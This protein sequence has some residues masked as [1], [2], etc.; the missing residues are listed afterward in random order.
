M[1]PAIDASKIYSTLGNN[2]SLVPLAVKDVANSLGLTT[3]S[4]IIG[5]ELEGKDRF[6]DEFGTQAIWLFGLP[7]F[8]K[9]TD[10]TLYKALK[11]DPK[12]DVRLLDNPDILDKAIELEKNDKIKKSLLNMKNNP[13]FSRSLAL[14]KFGIATAMT[15]ISYAALT[16]YRHK[17][18]KEA[19]KK[20]ILAEHAKSIN[21]KNKFNNT[22][23]TFGEFLKNSTNK[24]EYGKKSKN[25]SFTGAASI[26]S[27]LKD[28]MFDPVKN[29]MIVDGSI[30][31]ERLSE[32]RNKQ[33]FIG[34]SIKEGA[35][36]AFMYFASRPIQKFFEKNSIQ[37]HNKSIDLDARVIESEDLKNAF[38]NKKIVEESLKEFPING[39]DVEIYEFLH[40][41]P[42]NFVVQMAKKSDEIPTLG[43]SNNWINK[44]KKKLNISH[45]E[46]ENNDA[47]DTRKFIDIGDTKNKS[48]VKGVH[49]KIETLYKQYQES[50]ENLDNFLKKVKTLKRH[51]VLKNLGIC[52][53]ALGVAVPAIMIT[54]RYLSGDK[55]FQVKEDLEKEI[56]LNA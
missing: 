23:T 11:I 27:K 56:E 51:S 18:T 22:R 2:S 4:Y 28:F 42:D 24:N 33:E 8:K 14:S 53:G 32:S 36:W 43:K 30:T 6:L 25:T 34:Y 1:I 49:A 47:I 48:G 45:I 55:E 3:G 20:E 52:I 29:L 16:K 5:D 15:I 12:V 9:I 44:L 19:A 26:V 7:V 39:S 54:V 40:K 10:L 38:A 46:V 41:N 50:G 13:K 37:K 21:L 17:K 31:T 35:T